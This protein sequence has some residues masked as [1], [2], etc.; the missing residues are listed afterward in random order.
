[1]RVRCKPIFGDEVY[2]A[3][4]VEAP[5]L[6]SRSATRTVLEVDAAAPVQLE[7]PD[8]FGAEVVEA[9]ATEWEQLR[10]AGF[11]LKQA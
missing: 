1:M 2:P 4:L 7:P 8:A 10:D 9:T 5:S 3:N 11:A 6:V